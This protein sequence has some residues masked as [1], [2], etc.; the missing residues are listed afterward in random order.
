MKKQETVY[1]SH[2]L[3]PWET[4]AA[5][6]EREE[7]ERMNGGTRWTEEFLQEIRENVLRYATEQFFSPEEYEG[8]DIMNKAINRMIR[9]QFPKGTDFDKVTAAEVRRVESWLN[10][11]PREILGF[12][13]SAQAFALAF[14]RAA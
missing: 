8:A 10:N 13:S 14:D 11:Y 5:Q 3:F 6:A 7:R 4:F 1:I 2:V 12:L 9:R